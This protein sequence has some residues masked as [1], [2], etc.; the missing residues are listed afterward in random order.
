MR[1]ILGII[2]KS[3]LL[4]IL[5]IAL[6]RHFNLFQFITI[7]PEEQQFEFGLAAYLAVFEAIGGIAWNYLEKQKAQIQ[8]IFYVQE[9]DRNIDNTPL[10]VCNESTGVAYIKCHV[11]LNGNFKRL[12]NF[13]FELPLPSWLD[14]QINNTENLLEYSDHKMRWNLNA[15]LPVSDNGNQAIEYD[16]KLGF[17]KNVNGDNREITLTPIIQKKCSI[18]KC[19]IQFKTNSFK[20]RNGV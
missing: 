8:C 17:I 19:G 15:L 18:K 16:V 2:L 12:Q 11:S 5:S 6:L 7:I 3:I 13:E 1:K 20:V 4:P 14:S 10:I 9:V